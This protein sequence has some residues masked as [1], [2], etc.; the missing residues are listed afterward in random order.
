MP[1]VFHL[2]CLIYLGSISLWESKSLSSSIAF[3][4]SPTLISKSNS[5]FL[6]AAHISIATALKCS[7]LKQQSGVASFQVVWLST[8]LCYGISVP[9]WRYP[10][11]RQSGHEFPQVLSLLPVTLGLKHYCPTVPASWIGLKAPNEIVRRK[12]QVSSLHSSSLLP[13]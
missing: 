2:S 1:E 9:G 7:A 8:C 4:I 13:P 10:H 6:I 5:T 12:K 3:Y 11:L